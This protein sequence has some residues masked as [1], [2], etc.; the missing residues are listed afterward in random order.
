M[1]EK[2]GFRT[3]PGSNTAAEHEVILPP[4]KPRPLDLFAQVPDLGVTIVGSNKSGVIKGWSSHVNDLQTILNV[5]RANKALLVVT[6]HEVGAADRKFALHRGVIVWQEAELAYYEALGEAIGDYAKYEIIHSFG[7]T[8]TEEK[9]THKV[10]A[11]RISQPM[12]NSGSELFMFSMTPE[13]LLKTCVVF[14][15]AGGNADAYQRMLR[16]DRLP[17]IRSFVARRDAVLPTNLILHLGNNVIVEPLQRSPFRDTDNNVITLSSSNYDLVVL[18]IPMEYASLEL[19]DGQHRLFGFVNTDVA[20]KKSFNL[21]VLGLRNL[22]DKIRQDTF[23]AINDNSRR[24][25]PNLVAFLKYT[26]DDAVCQSDSELMAIRVVVDLN[27][28]TPFKGTIRLLDIGKQKL[29]LKGLS[30]Y[31]LRGLLGPKGALRRL[32]PSNKPEVYTRVLRLYF[33]TIRAMFKTEWDHPEKYI[34]ATNRGTSAFLKL[35]KS[36]LLTHKKKI[37]AATVRKYLGPLKSR[38]W[39]YATLSKSYVG[40][41]GWKEFYSELAKVIKKKHTDFE[42]L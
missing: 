36:I 14:R 1:F 28:V 21:V 18:S 38:D 41:Q 37:G 9:D 16:R 13:R 23:V 11:V 31:D 32:Y 3:E 24:M 12:T 33:S 7:I 35:L 34:V 19:I 29:T 22:P 26:K 39:D 4:D 40:S 20:T 10:L 15:R 27:N 5:S 17:K 6:G 42:L 30:G 2:A 8:T 25:D